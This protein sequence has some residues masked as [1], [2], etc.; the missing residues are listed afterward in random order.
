MVVKTAVAGAV[1]F[2]EASAAF[3]S[4]RFPI[5]EIA[6]AAVVKVA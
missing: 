6:A 2:N 1:Y 5:N 4:A 3:T